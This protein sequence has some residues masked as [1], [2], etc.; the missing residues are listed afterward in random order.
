[1]A[2]LRVPEPPGETQNEGQEGGSDPN[3]DPRELCDPI[4]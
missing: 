2:G 3:A 1:M 4:I